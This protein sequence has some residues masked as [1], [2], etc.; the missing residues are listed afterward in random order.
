M[1]VKDAWE[2]RPPLKVFY[3]SQK[4]LSHARAALDY[5]AIVSSRHQLVDTPEEAELAILHIEP[6]TVATALSQFPAL[7]KIYRVG[8]FLWE[9]DRLPP[10]H[11]AATTLVNEVWTA[12]AFCVRVFEAAHPQVMHVP[13]VVQRTHAT[14]DD[15]RAVRGALN[16]DA[17]QIT[18]LTVSKAQDPRKN[19]CQLLRVWPALLAKFPQAR[20]IVKNTSPQADEHAYASPGITFV[21][22]PIPDPEMTALLA[23][24]DIV[25][26]AH[27]A[28]GWGYNLADAM[29]LG[30]T[31]VATNHSGNLDFMTADNSFL[32]DATI[33]SIR[34]EDRFL[35]FDGHMQWAYLSDAALLAQ[36][37]AACEAVRSQTH[38]ER[39]LRGQKSVQR[40]SHENVS[41]IALDRL[42]AIGA[43]VRAAA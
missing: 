3:L 41:Q 9:A 22:Q 42:A 4:Y 12:S 20:L 13:Y 17:A 2:S 5:C 7:Q 15:H 39:C 40:F 28:E 14:A 6:H 33:E 30:K 25:V 36:L 31:A 18:L 35:M 11:T 32:I 34:P 21:D 16:H 27:H 23:M 38:H 26:S 8:T 24:S 10:V 37:E 43:R 29:W 1:A 19:T